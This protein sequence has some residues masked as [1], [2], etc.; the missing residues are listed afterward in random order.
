MK[1]RTVVSLKN[2]SV[3]ITRAEDDAREFIEIVKSLGGTP[4]ALAT[5]EIIP[6]DEKKAKDFI[7]LL[8]QKRHEFCAFMSAQAVRILFEHIDSKTVISSLKDT[9]VVAI[10]PKTL[11]ELEKFHLRAVVP[12]KFSSEGLVE[13]LASVSPAGK[14]IIIP[15]SEAAA[16]NFS[17]KAFRD[18]GMSI[19]EVYLYNVRPAPPSPAWHN[20]TSKLKA[21]EIH[22][23]IFSSA[24]NVRAFMQVLK[25]VDPD[26]IDNNIARFTNVISIGPTTSRELYNFGITHS[27]AP[28]HTVKGAILFASSFIGSKVGPGK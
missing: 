25:Q 23:L 8:I 17:S 27:E 22:A 11:A 21:R 14:K 4:I 16:D 5:T 7:D 28:E 3:A 9:T 6:A 15:R 18:L 10:G 1:E 24:S 12:R 19:D 2:K 26:F 13:M 20:F